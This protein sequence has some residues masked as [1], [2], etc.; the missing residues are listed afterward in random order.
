MLG[1][2]Q[3]TNVNETHY[4]NSVITLGQAKGK[5]LKR[6]LVPFGEYIPKPLITINQWL[7]L[8]EPNMLPGKKRKL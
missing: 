2:L 6:Q 7:H 4:Y 8:P 1:I 5:K 3:P